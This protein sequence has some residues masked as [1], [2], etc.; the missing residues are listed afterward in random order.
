MVREVY[1]MWRPTPLYRA[2]GL[3][4]AL[5]TDCRIFYK[6]EGVSPA[7][8]HKPNTAVPQAYYNQQ[9]GVKRHRDRDGR[10]PVGLVAR[11]SPAALFGIEVKVY[12]VRC[13]V[14][15]EAVPAR[16]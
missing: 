6:Y 4:Q 11:R 1:S 14:R 8:S 9:E 15:H 3:E 2:L 13:L 7:G 10:R 12:M 5:G 16:R